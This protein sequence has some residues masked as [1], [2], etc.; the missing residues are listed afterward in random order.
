M[1]RILGHV[2]AALEHSRGLG[3]LAKWVEKWMGGEEL[4]IASVDDSLP[5][6][7]V[8]QMRGVTVPISN[9]SPRQEVLFKVENHIEM[10]TGRDGRHWRWCGAAI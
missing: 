10:L 8:A 3:D 2:S 5:S 7:S 9:V 6:W 4:E 1:F